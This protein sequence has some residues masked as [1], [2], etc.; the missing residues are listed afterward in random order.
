[1]VFLRFLYCFLGWLA[2]SHEYLKC[3]PNNSHS[4]HARNGNF[5]GRLSN[6]HSGHPEWESPPGM[7][8]LKNVEKRFVFVRFLKC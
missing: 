7:G 3:V 8:I 1:M 6:S 4:G 2:D 5:P